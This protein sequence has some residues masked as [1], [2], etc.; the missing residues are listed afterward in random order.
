MSGGVQT[1]LGSSL[2]P[3]V[4]GGADTELPEGPTAPGLCLRTFYK[5]GNC[6]SDPL[7]T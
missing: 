3:T 1:G 7:G 4:V 6:I 5:F 2:Q